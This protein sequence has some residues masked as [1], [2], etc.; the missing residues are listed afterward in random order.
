MIIIAIRIFQDSAIAQNAL[1]VLVIYTFLQIF[2]D[3]FAPK[4]YS[5]LQKITQIIVSYIVDHH[6][7]LMT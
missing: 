7:E 2:C 5:K 1:D 3:V 4:N 6:V